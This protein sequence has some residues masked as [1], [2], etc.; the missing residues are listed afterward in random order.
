[1]K[2]KTNNPPD[3]NAGRLW[4]TLV[5]IRHARRSLSGKLMVVML[6]TTAIA[7]AAAGAALLFTDLRDNRA[8]WAA[9][10]GTEA[11]ILSL[12][13]QPALSFDDREGAQ[14]NL[15]ALQ[16]R[17][18][19]RAAALY[20]ADGRLFAQYVRAGETSAPTLLPPLVAEAHIEGGRV[21]LMRQVVQGGE[22]L[23][24]IYLRAHYDVRGRVRAYLSVLGAVMVIGLIAALLASSW[25]QRV[26]SQPMESMANVA[27]QIVEERDYSFRAAR[28]TNDEIGVV[29]DAF[30]NMLDEVQSRSRA[31]ETSEKLYRAIGES[32]NYGVWVTDAE[33]RCIYASESFLK[34]LGMSM[35][36]AANDGWGAVLHPDDIEVT[37]RAWKECA[38][39]GN[40]WYREHRMRGVDGRYH[41]ILAQGVPIRDAA[42]HI[43]RWAGI[44]LDI[45]RLKNTELALLE[46]DRRKD[47]FL[48]T[49]AHELRNPLAPIRNAVRILD[50][51]AADDRQ[52]K[53]GRE[54]I[55]RQVQRM[56]LLLDDLLDVSRITRGQLEL[57]K[58]Y[59]DLKSVVSV[60][61]E[62][63]RP[64]LDAKRHQLSVNLPSDNV[65]L[66]ADP[67]RLSQVIGNLLTNAAKYTDPEGRIELDARLENAELTI[68]IRDNGIGL[69]EE[70]MPGLFTM[71]SQVNSAIDRAE[72]GLGIGLALVKGLVA[73]H[74]GRV[75]VRSEGLGRGSEFI[76]HLPHKVLAPAD[77]AVAEPEHDAAN[78]NAMRRGRVLV[79]DDNRDAAESLGLVLRF[80]GYEVSIAYGGAEA[81]EVA[82]RERPSAAIIDIGMPGMSGHEVARR[83]RLE[84]WGRHAIL[85][86]LTGWGQDSDKQAARA[87]GFDDHLTKPVDPDDVEVVLS[88]LLDDAPAQSGG[89]E[90]S[91]A[92][93]A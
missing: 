36:Q 11:A 79:A 80:M 20:G 57:K 2:L 65:R 78:A 90:V 44:N 81:L 38:R 55:S 41:S 23:G 76:V 9:D 56:S 32:I 89:G 52:R 8:A 21:E 6:T 53:W 72:G 14:R 58:D 83:M 48:A 28:T 92:S 30:N 22:T 43:Q 62:T 3:R 5:S 67:L 54:V 16:A 27:R 4:R 17:A 85:I 42:G 39:T 75:E 19:I 46:A 51:D 10:L 68:T 59:V 93:R 15:N 35:D 34:L 7:L 47:E 1:V 25:L 45:S 64:L 66:E 70:V 84:A 24:T 73:L 69:N 77:A 33:G 87:A 18:S 61:V 26:V 49:L 29:V 71:F 88:K 12:A 82:A 74:G 91:D 37:M 60:A 40:L 31:L 13:V 63:A 86:A 50:S